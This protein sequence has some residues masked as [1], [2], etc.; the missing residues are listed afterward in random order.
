MLLHIGTLAEKTFA[1]NPGQLD[2]FVPY[3]RTMLDQLRA[4]AVFHKVAETGSF[5]GAAKALGISPSVVSHHVSSLESHLG[6]ALLYR[7]TRKLSLTDE[8]AKLSEAAKAMTMAA[9]AGLSSVVSNEDRPSG[10]LRIAAAG[11]VFQASPNFDHLAAFKKA[12]PG[13]ALSISFS[14]QKIELLGSE[15]DVAFRVGWL[16]NSQYKQRKLMELSRVLVVAPDYV[17][18]R[19]LPSTLADLHSWDWIKLAQLPLARQLSGSDSS[20][21]PT[22]APPIAMEVDSVGALAVAARLGLGVAAIPRVLVAA[23]I[24]EGRLTALLSGRDLMP[25]SVHAVWP[26]NVAENG[27][28]VRFVRYL[29]DRL[30]VPSD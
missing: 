15:F 19:R 22:F 5:R 21:P 26:N 9:E 20:L 1:H 30:S 16:E 3:C 7:T 4:M 27:L 8:G 12:Y 28:P 13:V 24:R 25:V 6:V 17:S 10:R 29:A 23:D 11:A 2:F 18:Q 14:D